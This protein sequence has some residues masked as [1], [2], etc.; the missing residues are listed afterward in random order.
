LLDE[1]QSDE[2]VKTHALTQ[3]LDV[4]RFAGEARIEARLVD[5]ATRDF[6][7]M[8]RRD[9]AQA[10]L[11]VWRLVQEQAQQQAQH[12][13]QQDRS[14][15]ADVALLYCADGK[16][17]VTLGDAPAQTQLLQPGDTLRIDSPNRLACKIEGAGALLAISIRYAPR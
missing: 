15:S 8:V 5:G 3:A 11:E 4:A 13:A 1:A 9:A 14:L 10:E 2:A 16:L 12:Q 17:A 7:L 6:N